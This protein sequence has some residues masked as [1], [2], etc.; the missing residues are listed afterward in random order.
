MSLVYSFAF[1]GEW[2][3][4]TGKKWILQALTSLCSELDPQ[5][6]CVIQV[7]ASKIAWITFF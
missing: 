1:I 4:Y 2:F 5:E 6:N 3:L 7:K